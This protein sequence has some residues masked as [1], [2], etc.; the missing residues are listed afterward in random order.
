MPL[1]AQLSDHFDGAIKKRGE[2]YFR[3]GHV[4]I[5]EGGPWEVGA[6][7][8][9]SESYGVHL[10]R[11]KEEIKASCTCPY[12]LDNLDFCKHI[13][14]TLLAA[15]KA[16]YL[17]GNGQGAVYLVP[18]ED[19]VLDDDELGARADWDDDDEADID[20]D[21]VDDGYG[22]APYRLYPPSPAASRP[23]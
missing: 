17:G 2:A 4:Q 19:E 14:A 3:E 9:G 13:W 21:L 8:Q 7:V 18:D 10:Q 6:H 22:H 20:D 16:C 23:S 11:T 15:E 12:F 5:L 1:A